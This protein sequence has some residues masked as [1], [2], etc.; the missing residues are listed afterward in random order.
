LG[1]SAGVEIALSVER[2]VFAESNKRCP[3]WMLAKPEVIGKEE[4]VVRKGAGEE[5]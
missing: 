1:P 4:N 5:K 2:V 3:R